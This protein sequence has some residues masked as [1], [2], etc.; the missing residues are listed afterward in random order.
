MGI[1]SPPAMHQG[2]F[3]VEA[4]PSSSVFP[5]CILLYKSKGRSTVELICETQKG[6]VEIPHVMVNVSFLSRS[7]WPRLRVFAWQGV[8]LLLSLII[9]PHKN[10]GRK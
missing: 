7:K 10:G 2:P 5:S 9:C 8:D 4:Q 3:V 1:L 6:V